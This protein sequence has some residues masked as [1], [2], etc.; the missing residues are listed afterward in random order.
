MNRPDAS[1]RASCFARAVARARWGDDRDGVSPVVGTI[2]ILVIMILATGGVMAWGVPAIQGLQDRAEYQNVLTQFLQMDS[3]VRNLRDPQNTRIARISMS[4]GY[5]TFG[6]GSRWVVSASRHADYNAFFLDGWENADPEPSSVVLMGG[7]VDATNQIS[8]DKASGG[9]LSNAWSCPGTDP[10][11]NTVNLGGLV[12]GD[13]VIRIQLKEGTV[14]WEA[15]IFDVGRLS[16]RLTQLNDQNQLHFEM[17]ALFSQHDSYFYV[18][19]APTIKDPDYLIDTP[20]TNLFVRV[21]HLQGIDQAVAGEGRFPVVYHLVDNYGASR[22]RT[23]FNPAQMVRLQIHGDLEAAFCNYFDR[24]PGWEQEDG[25]G[26]PIAC[27]A[28]G[29]G[30]D[31]NLRFE[32]GA[33]ALTYDLSHSVVRT[34]VRTI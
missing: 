21:L 24:R 25:A 9:T 12:L 17:G 15:W 6:P 19:E 16:Y 4:D 20:D 10:C 32:K 29:T 13:D 7:T 26:D 23:S 28:T 34:S 18:Q 22:G 3:D 33:N 27:P 11:T 30:G 31:V 14:R 5:L 8:V 1:F 2:L